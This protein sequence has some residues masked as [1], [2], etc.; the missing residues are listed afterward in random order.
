MITSQIDTAPKRDG[1]NIHLE[2]GLITS[3]IDTAPKHGNQGCY[4][5]VSL[6][7]SQIDTAP[8]HVRRIALRVAKF[9]YQSD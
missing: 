5:H 6:I 3:Q 8:K 4:G 1:E 9:D 2:N 7:T